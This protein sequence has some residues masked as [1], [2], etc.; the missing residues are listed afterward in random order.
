MGFSQKSPARALHA[1]LMAWK[2]KVSL[3][4]TDSAA[5]GQRPPAW[6]SECAGPPAAPRPRVTESV[7]K[8]SAAQAQSCF[9]CSVLQSPL[10]VSRREADLSLILEGSGGLGV[11]GVAKT[12]DRT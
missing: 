5:S 12:Q 8:G 7:A 10:I 11:P 9:K 1:C 4:W 2:E 3:G 6:S